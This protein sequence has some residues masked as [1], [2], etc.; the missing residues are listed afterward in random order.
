MDDVYID[1][2]E[3][4]KSQRMDCGKSYRDAIREAHV[5]ILETTR[6]LSL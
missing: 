1:K 6:T 2:A 4:H 5:Q 3:F